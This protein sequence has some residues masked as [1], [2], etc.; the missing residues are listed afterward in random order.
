MKTARHKRRVRHC[1]E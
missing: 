1:R